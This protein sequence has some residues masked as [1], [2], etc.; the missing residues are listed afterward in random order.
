MTKT[1]VNLTLPSVMKAIE[2]VLETYPHHPYQQAFSIPNWRQELIAH[3]LSRI[4]NC[5]AVV[6]EIEEKSISFKS[7]P[8]SL[9][10]RSCIE[11]LIH[12]GIDK[13]LY[14]RERELSYQIPQDV[15]PD[16]APSHWFG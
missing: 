7:L 14:K 10:E 2:D 8:C 1:I 9:E 3:V 5:Y 13:I 15:E 4:S 12:Q 16:F 6:D 11:A